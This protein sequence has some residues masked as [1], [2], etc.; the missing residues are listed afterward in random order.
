MCAVVDSSKQRIRL[1]SLIKFS[2]MPRVEP[3]SGNQW[4]QYIQNILNKTTDP[5]HDQVNNNKVTFNHSKPIGK[6]IETNDAIPRHYVDP[7]PI[8]ITA[9]NRKPKAIKVNT[10]VAAI[11][12]T[13]NYYDHSLAPSFKHDRPVVSNPRLIRPK[14]MHPSPYFRSDSL[15]NNPPYNDKLDDPIGVAHMVPYHPPTSQMPAEQ[16]NVPQHNM[17]YLYGNHPNFHHDFNMVRNRRL[18]LNIPQHPNLIGQPIYSSYDQN[19]MQYRSEMERIPQPCLDP[20]IQHNMPPFNP[21]IG[22][23]PPRPPAAPGVYRYL[24]PQHHPVWI[25]PHNH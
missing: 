3:P 8:P 1:L 5:E 17:E 2:D 7:R 21:S 25:Y 11:P 15:R 4:L 12:H 20:Y 13:T 18:P 6:S 14:V 10:A 9:T 19:Y 24:S 16:S 22:Y 23:F